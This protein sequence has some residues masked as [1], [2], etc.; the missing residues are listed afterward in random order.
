MLLMGF[1]GELGHSGQKNSRGVLE[2]TRRER[3]KYIHCQ[4]CDGR[5]QIE[6]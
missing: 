2:K 3:L 1:V 6:K 4:N 5:K